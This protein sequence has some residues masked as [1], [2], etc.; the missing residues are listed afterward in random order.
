MDLAGLH[1][2]PK[3]YMHEGLRDAAL[4]YKLDDCV[5]YSPSEEWVNFNFLGLVT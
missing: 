2:K 3:I 1:S 5:F 4:E